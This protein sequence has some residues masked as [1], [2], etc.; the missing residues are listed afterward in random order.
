MGRIRR[1]VLVDGRIQRAVAREFGLRV[2]RS[3]DA[4]VL[5]RLAIRPAAD[6]ASKAHPLLGVSTRFSQKTRRGRQ[7]GVTP[8][9]GFFERLKESMFTGATGTVRAMRAGT[10]A[11]REMFVPL[12]HPAG[13]RR[14]ISEKRWW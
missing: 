14:W 8:R 3:E 12:I 5:V 2:I 13:R 7:A 1:A 4:T 11:G 9:S 10:A 6:Q